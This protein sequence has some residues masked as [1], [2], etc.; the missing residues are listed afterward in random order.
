MTLLRK[1]LVEFVRS[2][3]HIRPAYRF[4]V[5]FLKL[6][7]A[8]NRVQVIIHEI[9]KPGPDDV[10]EFT[11]AASAYQHLVSNFGAAATTSIYPS[12]SQFAPEFAA[13]CRRDSGFSA[14]VG[15]SDPEKVEIQLLD[16]LQKIPGVT[17]D[18][19]RSLYAAGFDSIESIAASSL[20]ELEA[21]NG[22]SPAV[23]ESLKKAA[24]AMVVTPVDPEPVVSN[25]FG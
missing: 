19:A 14:S 17:A 4:E 3:S 24:T 23:S 21:V 10:G 7:A 22:V 8:E 11:D 15:P 20:N 12:L 25:P 16:S 18:L 9:A 13:V 5:P 2:T 6:Q 1:V